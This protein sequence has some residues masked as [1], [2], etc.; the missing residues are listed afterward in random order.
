M[1]ESLGAI[2]QGN[3]R[4]LQPGLGQ[5]SPALARRHRGAEAPRRGLAAGCVPAR[6]II[7][8]RWTG[9]MCLTEPHCRLRPGH[10]EDPRRTRSRRHAIPSPAPRSSSPAANTTSP[11]TS[12]TW[13]WR[14]CPMRRPA[15]RAS[16]CSSCRS[17]GRTRRHR[18]ASATRCAADRIEH[19]MGI[20]GSATCVINFDGAQGYLIGEPN[21]GLAAMFTMMNTA[22]LAVGLQGLGLIDRALPERAALCARPRAEALAV[23]REIPRQA[24]RP[25]HRASRCPPHAADLQGAGRRLARAGAARRDAWSTS[26]NARRTTPRRKAADDCSAS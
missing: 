17:E 1:P 16:P 13:C 19:K 18:R 11:T 12:S 23:G 21:K 26:W 15:P 9:T 20:H 2:S 4:R 22:R 8:G 6:P 25:D 3:A 10:V 7:D 5:L 24:G 14:A